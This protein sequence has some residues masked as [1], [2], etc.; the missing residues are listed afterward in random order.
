LN[1]LLDLL[2]KMRRDT[3][4]FST[5]WRSRLHQE[6]VDQLVALHTS[7]SAL[8]DPAFHASIFLVGHTADEALL[9][10]DADL[11]HSEDS[12]TG[13][14]DELE[15][16]GDLGLKVWR[17]T[18]AFT[19][20]DLDPDTDEPYRFGLVPWPLPNEDIAK[21]IPFTSNY[22]EARIRVALDQRSATY[23]VVHADPHSECG[24]VLISDEGFGKCITCGSQCYGDGSGAV[25]CPKNCERSL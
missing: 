13:A 20:D 15:S 22:D 3:N 17:F 18:K 4:D 11:L 2:A 23:E 16:T 1:Q 9:S 8:P 6:D 25:L 5:G 12:A 19:L 7:A 21:T 10:G 24:T 14:L